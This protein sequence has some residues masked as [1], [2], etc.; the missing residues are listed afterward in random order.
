MTDV[1]VLSENIQ[2]AKKLQGTYPLGAWIEFLSAYNYIND[3][4]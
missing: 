2:S 4:A 1:D 3:L